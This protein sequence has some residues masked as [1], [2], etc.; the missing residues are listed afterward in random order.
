[1]TI[2]EYIQITATII[3]MPAGLIALY[4]YF[5]DKRQKELREWQ[6]VVIYKIL[7]QNETRGL[8]FIDLLSKYRSE[9]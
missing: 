8:T 4:K 5:S 6:K 7:R 3:G 2:A 9:A 1:M